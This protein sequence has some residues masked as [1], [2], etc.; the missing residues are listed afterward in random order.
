MPLTVPDHFALIEA[1]IA[2][3]LGR[4]ADA[5]ESNVRIGEGLA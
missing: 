2:V 3:L 1:E 4:R 5:D